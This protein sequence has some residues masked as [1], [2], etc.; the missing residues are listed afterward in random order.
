T[1]LPGSNSIAVQA[2]FSGL[3][4]GPQTGN[5]AIALSDGTVF[6]IQV[7]ALVTGSV[8][9][10]ARPQP[11]T[12]LEPRAIAACAGGIPGSFVAAFRQPLDQASLQVAVAQTLQVQIVDGCGNP[13]S[14]KNGGTA[15]AILGGNAALDLHDAGNGI[16]ENTWTPV[17]ASQQLSLQ[18]AVSEQ[19]AGLA[20]ASPGITV[21]VLPA[22]AGAAG[23]PAGIVNAASGAHASLQVAS[24]G[25]YVAIYGTGLSADGAVTASTL[26]FPTTLNGTQLFL[27]DKPLPLYYSSPGQVNALIPQDLVPDTSY[28][29]VVVRGSTRSVPVP[30]TITQAEPGI[31]TEN[32]SGSGQGAILIGGTASLA[33][34]AGPNSR[35]VVRGQEVLAV[36]CTGLGPV[37]G[38]NGEAPP[39]DG[40][41]APATTI[42]QTTWKVT[43]TVG[44]VDAP[45][46]FA[47][48]TPTLVSLYQVNVGVPA[49]VSPGDAVPVVIT[50]ADPA[51]GATLSSN[52]VTVAVQ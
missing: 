52:T 21:A 34:P 16:W 38:P 33:A 37:Q 42:F 25:S 49:G 13:L 4:P 7:E 10:I 23:Q 6:N 41:A 15:Q 24:P 30:L 5:V 35:P 39:A 48:F 45:V 22:S 31:Y 26:P 11:H 46:L 3:T 36:F 28:Q 32:A 9:A 20:P 29:L 44:G 43:A 1:L 27:G 19:G 18:V 2:D 51:T 14:Q 17:A 12:M 47:G 8:A 50:V 40:A